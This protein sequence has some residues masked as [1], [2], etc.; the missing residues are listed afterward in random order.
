MKAVYHGKLAITHVVIVH[1]VL[2][3][4]TKAT[5]EDPS[6]FHAIRFLPPTPWEQIDTAPKALFCP[7]VE[8]APALDGKLDDPAWDT[9]GKTGGFLKCDDNIPID[10]PA[11]GPTEVRL[12][13]D[14]QHLYL[15]WRLAGQGAREIAASI[16]PG[17]S[18][19][20]NGRG[21]R[22]VAI[23]QPPGSKSWYRWSFHP[24]DAVGTFS[25]S[26]GRDYQAA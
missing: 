18:Y 1:L 3:L 19:S 21:A 10:I 11:T 17:K 16:E 14:D 20:Y 4:S 5:A 23:L 24:N 12:C 2:T 26:E 9:A 8:A 15:G 7:K 25:Q 6:R 13:R 22:F